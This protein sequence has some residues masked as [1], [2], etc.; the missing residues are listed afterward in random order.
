MDCG[1]AELDRGRRRRHLFTWLS[2]LCVDALGFAYAA[3]EWR[4]RVAV[5]DPD[6]YVHLLWG[7]HGNAPGLLDGAAGLAADPAGGIWSVSSRSARIQRFDCEGH[8]LG[9]F[10][11][12][13]D[14][15]EGLSMP[16]GIALGP[17]GSLYVVDWGHHR[18]QRYASDGRHI[19]TYGGREAPAGRLR[20]PMDVAVD[21]D[22]DVYVADTLNHRVVIYDD[23]A[24][25]LAYLTGD[26]TDLSG[27]AQ[28][29]LEANPDMRAAL[30]HVPDAEQQLRRFTLPMGLA[31]HRPSRRLLVCD[32]ARG[33]I[34]IYEKDND[35]KP[36]QVNL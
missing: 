3:D 29:T 30:R 33:R 18:I 36:P 5:F 14:G 26:A 15:P 25:P 10:R 19:R 31:Y 17:D 21:D 28:L 2:G 35:Y 16:A 8:L 34:Q 27:W 20:Y 12:Q 24:R 4:D 13:G 23:R 9:G 11:R 6:G 7:R 22:G 1:L 32:T